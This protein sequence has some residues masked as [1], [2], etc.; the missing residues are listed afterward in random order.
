MFATLDSI[1]NDDDRLLFCAGNLSTEASRSFF[2]AHK[3]EKPSENWIKGL[4]P[5]WLR[6]LRPSHSDF[7]FIQFLARE[8]NRSTT[9]KA[10]KHIRELQLNST[11]CARNMQ[12][13]NGI[14]HASIEIRQRKTFMYSPWLKVSEFGKLERY[15]HSYI[16]ELAR[17]KTF[18][19]YHSQDINTVRVSPTWDI[20]PT[21][22]LFG[23]AV[24][25]HLHHASRLNSVRRGSALTE[26]R[27]KETRK[28]TYQ[29]RSW[30]SWNVSM[31]RACRLRNKVLVQKTLAPSPITKR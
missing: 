15:W 3:E 24:R 12:R 16:Y 5:N 31:C 20:S 8:E 22:L 25:P 23:V 17:K 11:S 7:W 21:F 30:R 29:S 13:A 4:Q 28:K 10:L 14:F 27:K 18:V 19:I 26:S 1:Y 2:M 6:S 9:R